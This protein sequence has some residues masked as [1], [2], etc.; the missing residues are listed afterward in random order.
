LIKA[1]ESNS[2]SGVDGISYKH[3]GTIFHNPDSTISYDF[4]DHPL[5]ARHLLPL[6]R[7]FIS[8]MEGPIT[9]VQT[10][11]GCPFGC[12]ICPYI[13]SQGSRYKPRSIENVMSELHQIL[14]EYKICNVVFRDIT[15]TLDRKRILKLCQ[16]MS[17][18]LPGLTWWCETTADLV[19]EEL[20]LAMKGAGLDAIS[21][22]VE[23]G[24]SIFLDK[25]W[26]QKRMNLEKTR[27]VFDLCRKHKINSRA[28]FVI[29]YPGE[30]A[31]QVHD[32]VKL[33]R[34]LQPTS[35][36]FLPFIELPG[37]IETYPD[38]DAPVM[39]QIRKAYLHYYLKP[40]NILR[41]FRNPVIL[42]RRVSRFFSLRGDS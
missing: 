14:F 24:S 41:Q 20:L 12:P 15:F 13:Y 19:D 28:Y 7:Y 1:F 32:T 16:E 40:A 11:R 39:K 10:A 29:G 17:R 21:I 18:L 38:I 2:L 36:Q 35:L 22:G 31:D 3:N 27:E 23:T 33:A 25:Y 34:Q 4:D 26:Q 37:A 6:D 42:T 5:P 30:T 8:G 9:T